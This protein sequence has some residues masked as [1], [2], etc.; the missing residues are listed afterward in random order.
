[1]PLCCCNTCAQATVDAGAAVE[2]L[3]GLLSL[4]RLPD[5][6]LDDDTC[7]EKLVRTQAELH[8]PPCVF[9]CASCPC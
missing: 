8:A 4:L 7:D 2:E 3:E 6:A 5:R 9:V 1:M